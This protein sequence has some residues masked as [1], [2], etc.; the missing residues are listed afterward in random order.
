MNLRQESL[1][2]VYGAS[3]HVNDRFRRCSNIVGGDFVEDILE[4][5]L[6]VLFM[7][8]KSKYENLRNKINRIQNRALKILLKV[9]L[10][11][12]PV[13]FVFGLCSLLS[14]WIRGY[15]V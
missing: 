3:I 13:A 12:I 5:I 8:F 7:P 2:I 6:S 15:W 9:L 10:V 4:L 1:V 11:L 14:F